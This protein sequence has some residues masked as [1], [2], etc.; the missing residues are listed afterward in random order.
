MSNEVEEIK[1]KIEIVDF[2]QKYV[3]L[4]KAGINYAGLC[5]FHNEKSPSFMVNSERQ[6]F[7]C[8]GCDE[9][10]D[11]FNFVMKIEGLEFKEALKMLAEQTGV[12]L[13]PFGRDG[14]DAMPGVSTGGISKTRLYELNSF[15]ARAWHQIL[16]KHP[17]AQK[18]RDYLAR[19]HLTDQTIQEW[20]IGFAPPQEVTRKLLNSKKFTYNEQ[21]SAGN[22]SRLENRVVFPISDLIGKVVGFTGRI[23]SENQD[24]PKYWNTPETTIFHK[25]KTIFGLDKAK[26]E[27]RQKDQ[28]ILV[29]GQM[30]VI[31]LHQA[32][33]KFA[34]ATSGTALSADHIKLLKRFSSNISVA[35]DQDAAGQKAAWRA[36]EIAFAEDVVPEIIVTT[37]GQDPAD[38][39]TNDLEGWK[40]AFE[41]RKSFIEW[42]IDQSIQDFGVVDG[43]AKKQVATKVLPWIT[44][45]INPVEKSHWIAELTS[46]IHVSEDSILEMIKHIP[47][48]SAPK[49]KTVTDKQTENNYDH[50]PEVLILGLLSRFPKLVH[51]DLKKYSQY[52]SPEYRISFDEL[53]A[54]D[55]KKT[56]DQYLKNVSPQAHKTISEA[57]LLSSEQYASFTLEEAQAEVIILISRLKQLSREGLKTNYANK[58]AEAERLGQLNKVKELMNE[59]QNVILHKDS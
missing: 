36:L 22:P 53:L 31:M 13:K 8:F 29:E 45:I 6:S 41:N 16:L 15:I 26:R 55:Q 43:A 14:R 46:R 5:P 44:R 40:K 2:I 17:S 20:Q 19:R 7:K 10:G 4:K 51:D 38:M 47:Q 52:F 32:D 23:I 1:S 25:G 49:T 28:I 18:A 11:V 21:T 37:A 54:W 57:H 9:G 24:G 58:I 30:D 3:P 39:V 59:F 34:V 56:F 27:I 48:E 33:F 50:S 42:I 12:V 35:F